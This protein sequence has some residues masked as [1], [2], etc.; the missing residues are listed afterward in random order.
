MKRKV[1]ELTLLFTTGKKGYVVG[2]VAEAFNA[3]ERSLATISG[4]TAA[5]KP[6][7]PV[8]QRGVRMA[9]GH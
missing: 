8:P 9:K 1:N 4:D 2:D 3:Y 6:N 7:K 5:E